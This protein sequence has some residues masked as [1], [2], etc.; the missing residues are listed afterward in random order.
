MWRS[1]PDR[2]RVYAEN[3]MPAVAAT[4][5]LKFA[6]ERF[7]ADYVMSKTS[8]RGTSVPL[9]Y[10]ESENEYSRADYEIEKLCSLNAPLRV[11]LTCTTKS[12]HVGGP[13]RRTRNFANGN[14]SFGRTSTK[15]QIAKAFLRW[16]LPA[17]L[18]RQFRSS[19]APSA[20][21]EIC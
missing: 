15:C 20:Q 6:K 21:K 14:P 7:T 13:L 10:I 5:G 3:V 12:V 9:I 4:L 16:L 18:K 2:T 11:L 17:C 1:K 8:V 19:I